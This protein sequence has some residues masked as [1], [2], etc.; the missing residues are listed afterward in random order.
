[1]DQWFAVRHIVRNG[2]MF[3]ERITLWRASDFQAAIA[4][5]R[6]EAESYCGLDQSWELL[7]LFQA[8][9]LDGESPDSGSEVFSLIRESDL[10]ADTYVE[11]FFATSAELQRDI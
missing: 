8:Y 7:D 4:A 6:Q 10:D 9:A 3:E 2:R 5:A 1:M 11:R